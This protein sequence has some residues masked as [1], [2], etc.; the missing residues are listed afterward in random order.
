MNGDTS[1]AVRE[2]LNAV[3]PPDSDSP[4]E[5]TAAEQRVDA[6][7]EAVDESRRNFTVTDLLFKFVTDGDTESLKALLPY[8]QEQH[9]TAYNKQ[10]VT[11]LHIAAAREDDTLKILL[12]VQAVKLDITTDYEACLTAL[13]FAVKAKCAKN[14]NLLVARGANVN[15][16]D[17]EG[18]MPLHFAVGLEDN[19]LIFALLEGGA[20]IASVLNGGAAIKLDSIQDDEVKGVLHAYDESSSEHT[21]QQ[22]S[23]GL[24]H[25]I[26]ANRATLVI[27]R[28]CER[29][30]FERD[31][32][33]EDM[34]GFLPL[35]LA[36]ISQHD[37]IKE[38]QKTL[39]TKSLEAF[40]H[41]CQDSH[42][43]ID[44]SGRSEDEK[45][46]DRFA[47]LSYNAL[48]SRLLKIIRE[49]DGSKDSFSEEDAKLFQ[50]NPYLTKILGHAQTLGVISQQLPTAQQAQK[51]GV[52]LK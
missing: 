7:V 33:A 15:I 49:A 31:F 42:T 24:H 14:V 20:R 32:W 46:A 43:A 11:P 22:Y 27:R 34:Q 13:H 9:V 17:S 4:P 23:M 35:D 29:N 6:A 47:K 52:R 40:E 51:R 21:A 45:R 10:V 26:T 44:S 25:A 12:G 8:L 30:T 28:W 19:E 48:A 38:I 5:K 2:T 39:L 3:T 18:R 41:F 16:S 50:G 37:S 1:T 36:M